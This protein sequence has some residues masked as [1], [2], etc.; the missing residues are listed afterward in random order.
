MKTF[1]KYCAITWQ[2]FAKWEAVSLTHNCIGWKFN[3]MCTAN[4]KI[5]PK[6]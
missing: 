5:M 1:K 4:T 2:H 3:R 6:K